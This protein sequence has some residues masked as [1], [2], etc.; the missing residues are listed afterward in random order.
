MVDIQ[1]PDDAE[2]VSLARHHVLE[3]EFQKLLLSWV[4]PKPRKLEL[5]NH[6]AFHLILYA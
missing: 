4:K 1:E 5:R 6:V 3:I 2:A